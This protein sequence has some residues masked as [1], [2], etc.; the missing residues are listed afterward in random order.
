[1][2]RRNAARQRAEGLR[3][4]GRDG[5]MMECDYWPVF[6]GGHYRGGLVLLWDISDRAAREQERDRR[7]EAELAS[8]RRR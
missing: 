5:G 7:L 4:A 6:A 3:F 8:R 2:A 1:M